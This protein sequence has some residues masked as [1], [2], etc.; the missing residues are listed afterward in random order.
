MALVITIIMLWS[1][2]GASSTC[3]PKKV[4]VV[5]SESSKVFLEFKR[6][7]SARIPSNNLQFIHSS[8]L[9]NKQ[10]VI[11]DDVVYVA[12]GQTALQSVIK[13]QPHAPTLSVFN[14]Y[15]YFNQIDDITNQP[16]S[17]IYI[18]P[19]PKKLIRLAHFFFPQGVK[20]L[21]LQTRGGTN[22]ENSM[23][24]TLPKGITSIQ[25]E[26][27]NN[28]KEITRALSNI[29][30]ADV[31]L[32]LPDKDIYDTETLK[33][34]L[35]QSYRRGKVI[36]GYNPGMVK[37][38]ALSTIHY[39]PQI[40]GS[41]V[42][43]WL[44]EY[45]EYNETV[46]RSRY[47]RDFNIAINEQVAR[48][49]EIPLQNNEDIKKKIIAYIKKDISLVLHSSF[50]NNKT[51]K[52]I[53]NII[54]G[55]KKKNE[56]YGIKT[57]SLSA[58]DAKVPKLLEHNKLANVIA[59]GSKAFNRM[60]ATSNDFFA[61]YIGSYNK[62]AIT[63][64]GIIY[65]AS[66]NM[67][68]KQLKKVLKNSNNRVKIKRIHVV[69]NE[70]KSSWLIEQAKKSAKRHQLT[71]ITYPSSS[72]KET[73]QHYEKLIATLTSAD[74]I[75]LLNHTSKNILKL[76]VRA[77]WKKKIPVF[78]NRLSDVEA[79]ILFA[80]YPDLILTGT[81]LASIEKNR[82]NRLT[83]LLDLNYALNTRTATHLGI[84]VST[85]LDDY[86]TTY[87]MHITE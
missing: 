72:I 43:S 42:E 12:V 4:M 45:C 35:L 40:I 65:T 14:S 54:K 10:T 85:V 53:N 77:S 76:I 38:G 37:A 32:A 7:V 15:D 70:N 66:P 47:P 26:Y 55:I 68:F 34:I 73:A 60:A 86:K 64:P 24:S 30:E 25:Y 49:M 50:R 46:P 58:T 31:I 71:L 74:S 67:Q 20:L 39:T 81:R 3:A 78:S 52:K 27:I 9:N 17:A 29:D 59:F 63:T 80:A 1:N 36:I 84:P 5:Y 11:N 87:P 22:Y 33:S 2:P 75:W 56:Q 83:P 79:G 61:V 6:D 41:E 62:A 82:N 18:D 51:E 8:M 28:K 16:V 21:V 69:Y 57:I 23:G 19:E 48:S 44:N 13:Y